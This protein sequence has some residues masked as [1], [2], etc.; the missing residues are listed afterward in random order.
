MGT[1]TTATV[2]AIEATRA[3]LAA[4]LDVLG[5]RLPDKQEATR[6]AAVGAG[7]VVAALG[8]VWF[9]W[10]RYRRTREHRALAAMLH[11]AGL[12]AHGARPQVRGGFW[13]VLL[14][15]VGAGA[16]GV[17]GAL[18]TRRLLADEDRLWV[19]P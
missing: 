13:K 4:D 6:A 9:G 11:D 15:L 3:R 5:A 19:E 2:T 10:S 18:A 1:D 14:G 8:S 7:T 17:G 16:V 12:E